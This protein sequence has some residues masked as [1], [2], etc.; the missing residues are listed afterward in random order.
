VDRPNNKQTKGPSDKS[1]KRQKY[2]WTNGKAERQM[3]KQPEQTYKW[4]GEWLDGH[5]DKRTEGKTDKWTGRCTDG[6]IDR[7]TNRQMDRW[8]GRQRDR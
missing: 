6:Y 1:K 8:T 2:I 3:N 5:T 4:T 7:R